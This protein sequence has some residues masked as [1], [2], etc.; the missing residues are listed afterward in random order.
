MISPKILAETCGKITCYEGF[1][2]FAAL[3]LQDI[4]A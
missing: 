3:I 4:I 1:V 2:S